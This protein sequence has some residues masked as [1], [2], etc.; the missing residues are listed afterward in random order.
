MAGQSETQVE[1]HTEYDKYFFE[2]AILGV[3]GESGGDEE[4]SFIYIFELFGIKIR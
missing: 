1:E 2:Y 4:M 3:A